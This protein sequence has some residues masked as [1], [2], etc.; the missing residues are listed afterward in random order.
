MRFV[1]P[2]RLC[3]SAQRPPPVSWRMWAC[4]SSGTT[5]KSV[6]PESRR[7]WRSSVWPG[8]APARGRHDRPATLPSRRGLRRNRRLS[9]RSRTSWTAR[10]AEVTLALTVTSSATP[11]G[12]MVMSPVFGANGVPERRLAEADEMSRIGGRSHA[13]RA[14]CVAAATDTLGG[15]HPRP[16]RIV[17]ASPQTHRRF[18]GTHAPRLPGRSVLPSPVTTSLCQRAERRTDT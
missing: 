11:F 5:R 15:N 16:I 12:C 7:W 10:S 1:R 2:G 8:S 3:R 17:G 18:R 4:Q 13:L 9:C 6:R 14:E